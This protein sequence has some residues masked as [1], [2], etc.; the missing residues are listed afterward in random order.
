MLTVFGPRR[1]LTCNGSSRRDFFKA[2]VL[3]SSGLL[4]SD[5][6]RGRAAAA[7][8]KRIND[9]SVIWLWLNGGPSQLET[10]DPK[11]EN[12][13]E[14]RSVVGSV[15]TN[16]PGIHLGGLFPKLARHADKLAVVRSFTHR[17]A[18]P[19]HVVASHQ[20]MT[21]YDHPPA[22]NGAAPIRPS[23]GSIL[24]RYRGANSAQT[25]L[26]TFVK[27]DHLYADG[28]T[29]LGKAYSPFH[30]RDQAVADMTPRLTTDR[31]TDRRTLLRSLD[32]IHRRADQT[33]LLQGL[34][35]FE[36]QAY[37]LLRN[38]SAAAFDISRE[39]QRTRERYGPGLGQHLLLARRM[40]EAGVGFVN[41]WYGGWDSHGINPSNGSGT[42]E[43]EIHKLAPSL[44]HS[45]SVL[46]EDLY[47]RS[48]DKKVLVVV[49]GEFGR[50]PRI[51]KD[52]GR[53][54]WP[55][56]CPLVLSGGGMKMGQVIGQSS[57]NAGEPATTPITPQDLMATL[58]QHLGM[59]LDLTYTDFT[60]RP[61]RMIDEGTPI[62]ELS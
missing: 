42:M 51:N 60:G 33:A 44:D 53:E 34:D 48:L 7:P 15:R 13:S 39:E 40:C 19:D 54:H 25:G 11:P 12:P 8:E 43:Q 61:M 35:A 62:A 27:T 36:V 32:A 41:V 46:L 21:G 49:T 26:P 16:I 3:G 29:W 47:A 4:L 37:E 18:Q 1:S 23:M 30:V 59:P 10:F 14:F 38:N 56:L 57:A 22:V 9:T 17:I 31:L 55:Q 2:G 6:L 52:R 28:P 58:F 45:L 5:L 20:V 24:A 50:S